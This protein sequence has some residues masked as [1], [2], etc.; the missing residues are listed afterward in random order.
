[1]LDRGFVPYD[2]VEIMDS[3]MDLEPIDYGM[4]LTSIFICLGCEMLCCFKK[5][6]NYLIYVFQGQSLMAEKAST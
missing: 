1:M 2:L 3:G 6:G 4:N 5:H